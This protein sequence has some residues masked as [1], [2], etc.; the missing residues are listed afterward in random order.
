M[1]KLICLILALTFVLSSVSVL[2]RE[3][4]DGYD[5]MDS[6][7]KFDVVDLLAGEGNIDVGEEIDEETKIMML[8]E[9]LGLWDDASISKN[10]P[11]TMHDFSKLLSMLKLGTENAFSGVYDLNP[12]E[13]YAT[14]NH[15]Y[16][17]LVEALGYSYLCKQYPNAK[18]ANIIVAAEIGLLKEKP[19]NINAYVTRGEL[20]RLIYKAMNMNLCVIEYPS[21]GGYRH[22]VVEGKTLLNSVHNIF[23]M[24]GLI[25]G[26]PGLNVY[27]VDKVRDG[28]IHIDGREI[29]DGGL[30]LTNYFGCRVQAYTKYDDYLDEYSLIAVDFDEKT[31]IF[32]VD[33]RNISYI[34]SYEIGYVD[35]NGNDATYNVSNLNYVIENGEILSSI[36]DIC[37]YNKNEGVI[38]FTASTSSGVIDTA[39][40]YKYNYYVVN[41]I[42][43]RLSRIILRYNRIHNG[44]PY[45]QLD[46]KAPINVYIDGAKSEYSNL[47][48]GSVIKV[49]QCAS[50]GYVRIDAM[51]QNVIIGE[52]EILDENMVTVDG[53]E[54][55]LAKDWEIFV[56]DN[57]DK[58]TII[59]QQRPKEL[60]LGVSTTFY[61]IDDIIAA[62]TSSQSYKYGYIRSISKD[63]TGIDPNLT[64]RIFDQDGEWN[65]YKITDN[66]EL[67]G[68]AKVSKERFLEAVNSEERVA[69]F[70]DH[71]VRFRANGDKEILALDTIYESMYEVDSDEDIVFTQNLAMVRDWTYE[72]LGRNVP[73][74]LSE[75]TIILVAPDGSN[76]ENDFRAISNTQMPAGT[77]ENPIPTKVYNI[78]EYRQVN[79]LLMTRKMDASGG[80]TSYFYIQK[81]TSA[82]IDAD[83]QIYGYKISGKELKG[84]GRANGFVRDAYFYVEESAI[85]KNDAKPGEDGYSKDNILEPGDFIKANVSGTDLVSWDM[86]LKGGIVPA[87]SNKAETVSNA[88]RASGKFVRADAATGVWVVDV[89]GVQWPSI[90]TVKVIIKPDTKELIVAT[91]SDFLEGEDVCY[92]ATYGRGNYFIKNEY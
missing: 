81:I 24:N 18:D 89:N 22:T 4:Y 10:E 88:Y 46:D 37:D 42:D 19:E 6:I 5:F 29:K 49:F 57:K 35:E 3:Y 12:T 56:D 30:D 38:R 70:F 53:E 61:V 85:D 20:A 67:E 62:Y 59:S 26:I 90:P 69:H 27:G 44:N 47:I 86:E 65:N 87:V 31:E 8:L 55:R 45:I 75:N 92:D 21:D 71:P 72:N 15:A 32:E 84:A 60:Q 74:F 16:T 83:D 23:L 14:Y 28:Y 54:Y 64:L 36:T 63:R 78:N 66:I 73:F 39:I 91:E 7:F 80:T 50:T 17:Y 76:D 79:L 33:F 25:S 1:K 52:P 58:T 82:V 2:A 9:T 48:S 11:V 77:L 51:S 41:N 34:N 43:T 68:E 13:E 40:I